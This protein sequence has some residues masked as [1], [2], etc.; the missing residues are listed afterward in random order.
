[1]RHIA[2]LS[3]PESLLVTSTSIA[4]ESGLSVESPLDSSDWRRQFHDKVYCCRAFRALLNRPLLVQ[5][6]SRQMVQ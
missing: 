1:M 3:S 4:R 5:S 6:T 2:V